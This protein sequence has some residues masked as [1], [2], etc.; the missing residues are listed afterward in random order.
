MLAFL[1]CKSSKYSCEKTT[2]CTKNI[3]LCSRFECPHCKSYGKHH[4][5]TLAIFSHHLSSWF[6]SLFN[7][8]KRHEVCQGAVE[9]GLRGYC[10]L[11][12]TRKLLPPILPPEFLVTSYKL[13]S[14]F[15]PCWCGL[16]LNGIWLKSSC[17][18][19]V[20]AGGENEDGGGGALFESLCALAIFFQKHPSLQLEMS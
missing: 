11:P 14:D 12:L 3:K 1:K 9:T 4:T 5:F 2:D 7:I 19:D 17:L 18:I 16:M 15:W 10:S 13:P 8:R 6:I 20:V